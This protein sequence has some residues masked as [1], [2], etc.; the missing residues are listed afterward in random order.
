MS[1]SV[2]TCTGELQADQYQTKMKAYLDVL[3]K[4]YGGHKDALRPIVE[5][6]RVVGGVRIVV[7]NSEELFEPDG[8]EVSVYGIGVSRCGSYGSL[9]VYTI[10]LGGNVEEIANFS[11]DAWNWAKYTRTETEDTYEQVLVVNM[12]CAGERD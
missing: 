8:S 10:T 5:A 2:S 7:S 3:Q 4:V 11:S 9:S 6:G 12:P 1:D